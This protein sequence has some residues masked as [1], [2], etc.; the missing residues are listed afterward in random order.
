M[1]CKECYGRGIKH[2]FDMVTGISTVG[3]CRCADK[4][5]KGNWRLELAHKIM[6]AQGLS[7][8]EAREYV[9]I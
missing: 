4:K 9:G 7:E 5:P 2:H 6:K 3:P 1:I 8:A